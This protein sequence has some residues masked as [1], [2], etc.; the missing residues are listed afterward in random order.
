MPGIQQKG[1]IMGEEKTMMAQNNIYGQVQQ[2]VKTPQ[3]VISESLQNLR[4]AFEQAKESLPEEMQVILQNGEKMHE[5]TIDMLKGEKSPG[6]VMDENEALRNQNQKLSAELMKK[7]DVKDIRDIGDEMS[8]VLNGNKTK[9]QALDSYIGEKKNDIESMKQ[10][11][12]ALKQ[13][14]AGYNAK[15]YM[16]D[17]KENMATAK[18]NVM[19]LKEGKKSLNEFM[20][21]HN[22]LVQDN[23]RNF[24][25][26]DINQ[27]SKITK[28][29]QDLRKNVKENG[30]DAILD[31]KKAEKQEI[32]QSK[33]GTIKDTIKPSA[34]IK[35]NAAQQKAWTPSRDI[36]SQSKDVMNKVINRINDR[37]AKE[38]F[39]T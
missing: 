36:I 35:E 24:A 8:D 30:I 21:D 17:F 14:S 34:G 7:S 10:D 4:N 38:I 3:P 15:Q 27:K 5:N 11:F 28:E 29:L 37:T 16:A 26:L 12:N 39:Q 18:E 33:P 22:K 1:D 25:K 2:P 31:P 19:D 6:Q 13:E 32:N 20:A 9:G 23:A